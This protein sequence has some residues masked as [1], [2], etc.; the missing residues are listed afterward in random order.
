M[1]W[2]EVSDAF[3]SP[4][5]WLVPNTTWSD[6]TYE[7]TNHK[8]LLWPIPMAIAVLAMKYFIRKYIFTSFGK[9]LGIKSVCSKRAASN[10]VLNA[11]YDKY[12]RINQQIMIGLLKQV[13]MTER[14]IERWW[15]NRRVQDKPSIQDKFS[16]SLWRFLQYLASVVFGLFVLW[17]KSWLWDVKQCWYG[18]P[19]HQS[20]NQDIRI[21]YLFS[22]IANWTQF[23]S[24]FFETKRKDFWMLVIHHI[25]ALLLLTMSWICNFH[26]AGSLVVVTL[27]FAECFLEAAKMAKYTNH[28]KL[29][30]VIFIIFLITWFA[31][32]FGF[33]LRIIYSAV[34]DISNHFPTFPAY[35]V[36]C[37]ML[38][39]LLCISMVWTHMILKIAHSAFKTGQVERDC[40]SSSSEQQSDSDSEPMVC[41]AIKPIYGQ[42]H[43]YQQVN[44][45][46]FN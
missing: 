9:A 13:D 1:D 22:I 23:V 41:V 16:E 32:R 45:N 46:C 35:Y 11:A 7:H 34:Y 3:W 29:C 31:T 4:S 42:Q 15:R 10:A 12:H 33:Y 19:T 18:Y 8:D 26:R 43:S 44:K 24:H 17:D 28:H 40:R 2:E 37:T 14:G 38:L 20:H 25:I 27:D 36:L 21:Y 6:I 30:N 5:F 39:M